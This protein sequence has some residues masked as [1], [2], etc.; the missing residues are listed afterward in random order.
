MINV[1]R[2]SGVFA[3]VLA[4]AAASVVAQPAFAA[5]PVAAVSAQVKVQPAPAAKA[6]GAITTDVVHH[7]QPDVVHHFP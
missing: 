1:S 4:I 6:A 5:Q 2:R 7:A 3:S